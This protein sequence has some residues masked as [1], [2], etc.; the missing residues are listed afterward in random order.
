M[1]QDLVDY[2]SSCDD[3]ASMGFDVTNDKAFGKW[4]Q[5]FVNYANRNED[6][7]AIYALK[8]E[9]IFKLSAM[10]IT[11]Y[12]ELVTDKNGMLILPDS[13]YYEDTHTGTEY[14][15][16]N[17]AVVYSRRRLLARGEIS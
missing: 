17:K 15:K 1:L 10:G 13:D 9:M 8:N 4:I 14:T 5:K 11:V 16:V 2:L 3:D 7:N 12:D 6:N